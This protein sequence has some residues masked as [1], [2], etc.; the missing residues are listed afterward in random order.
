M[1]N[2]KITTLIRHEKAAVQFLSIALIKIGPN[3]KPRVRNS[4]KLKYSLFNSFGAKR[5]I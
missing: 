3:T 5:S 1:A 2:N 4:A